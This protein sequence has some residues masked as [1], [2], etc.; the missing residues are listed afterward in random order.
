MQHANTRYFEQRTVALLRRLGEVGPFLAGS[1]VC[2]KH[3]C[4]NSRCRCATGE[5]HPSW[6]LTFKGEKQ[7]TVTVYVPMGLLPEVRQWVKNYR[8]F[9]T[10]AAAISEA[11]LARVRLYVTEQRR[12]RTR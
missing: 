8:L 7:K 6:R 2:V 10:L 12:R 5:G 4:G 1:L 3:R 11:Q 9:K